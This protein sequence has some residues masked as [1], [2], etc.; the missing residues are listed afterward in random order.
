MANR[1]QVNPKVYDRR[2]KSDLGQ[3]LANTPP[4]DLQEYHVKVNDPETVTVHLR[5]NDCEQSV[6]LDAKGFELAQKDMKVLQQDY[7]RLQ[8]QHA[9]LCKQLCIENQLYPE[10]PSV[11]ITIDEIITYV[12]LLQC[13]NNTMCCEIRK[14]ELQLAL[15]RWQ[16]NFAGI[17]L[18]E[19]VELKKLEF[20]GLLKEAQKAGYDKVILPFNES[21]FCGNLA[22][23]ILDLEN[24]IRH[25]KSLL[26][27]KGVLQRAEPEDPAEHL[28]R[29]SWYQQGRKE[30]LHAL[31]EQG[32]EQGRRKV[33]AMKTF[34]IWQERY[35]G[36]Q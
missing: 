28:H 8:T 14:F 6:F 1:Y 5:Q 11:R 24:S 3:I 12:P 32:R 31:E 36:I 22:K 35:K 9:S 7:Q 18:Q 23:Q 17:D 10:V 27:G 20:L 29:C 25:L 13:S 30:C 4:E 26:V 15:N 19:R 34:A 2:L 33:D 21:G 16:S